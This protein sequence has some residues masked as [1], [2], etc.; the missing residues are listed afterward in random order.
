MTSLED[1][2][3]SEPFIRNSTPPSPRSISSSAPSAFIV[4]TVILFSVSVPVLSVQ[5]TDVE[6]SVSTALSLFTRAFIRAMRIIPRASAIVATTGSPSGI[7]ATA[8]AIPV[9]IIRNTS[10]PLSIPVAITAAAV[11]RVAHIR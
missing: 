11:I 1:G 6:P 9:S 7:A 5:M 8:R 2:S 3:A 10:R 4:S